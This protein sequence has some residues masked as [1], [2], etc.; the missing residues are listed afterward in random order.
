MTLKEKY[1]RRKADEAAKRE[2]QVAESWRGKIKDP[3]TLFT[4]V[5]AVCTLLLVV[6]GTLQKCTLD[7][8]DETLRSE[9]RA[10]LAPRG[11]EIGA[12]VTLGGTLEFQIIYE[13]TG[14]EPAFDVAHQNFISM[15]DVPLDARGIAWWAKWPVPDITD[16]ICN[17]METFRR[18]NIWIG[19]TAFPGQQYRD[20]GYVFT[21]P[22]GIPQ[23]FLDRHKTF[24]VQGCLAYRALGKF[25]FS[26][27]C[28]YLYP[29]KDQLPEQWPFRFCPAG[30]QAK[31][32][33]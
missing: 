3:L 6:V 7:R 18:E 31:T 28:V 26:P 29:A 1:D 12:P 23:E 4:G 9:Q 22:K 16:A 20:V 32:P 30:N 21:D 2:K 8:T 14:K 11:G 25:W 17:G 19:R 15:L 5:L 10:W 27:Y 13:N 33:E 24:V